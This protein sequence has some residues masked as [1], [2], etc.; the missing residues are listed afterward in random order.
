MLFVA[1]T[2]LSAAAFGVGTSFGADEPAG[3]GAFDVGAYDIAMT[4]RPE[5]GTLRAV[6]V[7][8]ATAI[9]RLDRFAL[10]LSGPA[11]RAVTVNAKPATFAR[12]GAE[13]LV[14]VP[15]RPLA[16]GAPLRVRVEY[17]GTPGAGWL[18]TVSGGATA[19]QGSSG[20]WFPAHEDAHDRADFRL[21]ATVPPGWGV[22]SVGREEPVPQGAT[23]AVFR[24]SE[25][26]VDPAHLAVSVDRFA[27]ERS[28]LADGTPVVDAYAPGLR[29]A[30]AP[31]AH[32]LP[33]ILDF[34]AGRFGRYPFRAAGNVF[35]HVNDDGPATAPQTRPVYLGAGNA[36]FMTLDAVVHEQ[37]HQWYGVSA[38][39]NGPADACLAECFAVYATWLWNEAKDGAD[40]DARYRSQ[41]E[42]KK[43]DAGFWQELYRPGT[44][45][46]IG[47][48]GKGPLALHALR[49][50]VGEAAF[51][52]LLAQWP[53]EHRAGYADWPMFEAFA[54]RVVGRDL[55]GFLAAWF[56]A[57]GVPAEEYLRPVPGL[58]RG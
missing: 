10:H 18:P 16:P 31:L 36:R 15:A 43:D 22:V 40:L 58:R 42:E 32:R 11:V 45:P 19:F 4:Y 48:Y 9:A 24:W 1:A 30:T 53:R 14:I 26:N 2:V 28:T 7:V 37:A 23:A 47:M 56:R 44:A 39:A 21:T 41:V 25:P 3:G 51:G 34:L 33:E 57:A 20:A 12:E 52:R 29:E 54:Q 5:S 55:S 38:A 46:G 35:T 17:E 27:F 49:R 50:Y 6:A 13:E 8:D